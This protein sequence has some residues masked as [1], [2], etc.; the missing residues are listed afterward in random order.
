MGEPL[1]PGLPGALEAV[2]LHQPLAVVSV[3]KAPDRR[4]NLLEILKHPAIDDLLF[5]G[6]DEAFSHAIG[7]WLFDKGE[8]WADPPVFELVLKMI[9]QVLGAVVHPQRQAPAGV[10]RHRADSCHQTLGN[11]LQGRKS[12]P[13]FADMPAHALGVP[14][15]HGDEEP[16]PAFLHG[17]DL[18]AVGAPHEVGRLGDDLP[19]VE[20]GVAAPAPIGGEEVVLP[21]EPQHPTAANLDPV[22]HP[23]P[24]PHLAVTLALKR[25]GVQVRPDQFQE[26]GVREGGLRPPFAGWGQTH[27]LPRA[28]RAA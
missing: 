16:T 12:G 17:E 28:W 10:R 25:R 1:G 11:G 22:P 5:E 23:Q 14:V 6:P 4:P 13:Q 19:L 9:R 26:F 27:R 21:H 8:T 3:H 24:G 15:L 2:F 20:T 18:S 7:L